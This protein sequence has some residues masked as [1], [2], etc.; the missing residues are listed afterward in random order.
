VV[1]TPSERSRGDAP[2]HVAE[3][4]LVTLPSERAMP[5]AATALWPT[6]K[7]GVALWA[8]AI[9]AAITIG[10]IPALWI[11][12]W[13]TG[14]ETQPSPGQAQ[15]QAADGERGKAQPAEPGVAQPEPAAQPAEPA[16]PVEVA[17]PEPAAQPAMPAAA[18]SA[19]APVVASPSV[20]TVK[21]T[22][23]RPERAKPTPRTRKQ[24]PPCDVYRHP[25]GCPN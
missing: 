21:P 16:A 25:K 13:R 5:R 22:P 7:R 1:D 4:E 8:L 2:L 12:R 23:S 10:V 17:Q 20:K 11:N 15:P 14:D 9:L 19:R 18:G 3:H 24:P 6:T